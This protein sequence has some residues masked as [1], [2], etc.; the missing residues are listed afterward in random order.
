M[1]DI[2]KETNEEL[3]NKQGWVTQRQTQF[4]VDIK[5]TSM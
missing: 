5:K 2:L 3:L 1:T 4:Q